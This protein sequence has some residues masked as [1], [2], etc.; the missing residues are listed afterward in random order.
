MSCLLVSVHKFTSQA[1]VGVLRRPTRDLGIR[2]LSTPYT[3]SISYAGEVLS[4]A[5]SISLSTY[6]IRCALRALNEAA[7]L[8]TIWNLR[9]A[10]NIHGDIFVSNANVDVDA[11]EG[12]MP[13]SEV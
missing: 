7:L 13:Q 2:R 9:R 11:K 8:A 3:T 4:T 5:S 12:Q 1:G 6:Q 10:T